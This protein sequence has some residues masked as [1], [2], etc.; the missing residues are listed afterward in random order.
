ALLAVRFRQQRLYPCLHPAIEPHLPLEL[1]V[2]TPEGRRRFVL[3]GTGRRFEPLTGDPTWPER[4]EPWAGRQHPD[5][6]TI[7]LR[8]A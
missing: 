8:L 5:D 7:D 6:V 3:D 2:R 1:D 4:A